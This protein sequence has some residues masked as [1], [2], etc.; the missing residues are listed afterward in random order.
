MATTVPAFNPS[1]IEGGLTTALFDHSADCIKVLD[2]D[3]RLL[4]M[5]AP[6]LCAMEIDDF[7]PF[8]GQ[9]WA[10]LW[11]PAAREQIDAAV[12]LALGGGVGHLIAACP[13][14]KGTP[15]WW[16]VTVAPILAADGSVERLLSVSKDITA[17]LRR[18]E[19]RSLL[20][21]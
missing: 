14:A 18:S 17:L 20:A 16:D 13:T 5:S 9:P 2:V 11:P 4:A 10:E 7:A 6:G 12:E 19:A 15:K 8:V 1:A 21:Q 3:G